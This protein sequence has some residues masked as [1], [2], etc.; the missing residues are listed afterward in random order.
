MLRREDQNAGLIATSTK[1][2]RDP[3]SCSYNSKSGVDHCMGRE[4]ASQE[5]FST[6]PLGELI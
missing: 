6:E 3:T 4:Y 2:G 1:F 5:Y